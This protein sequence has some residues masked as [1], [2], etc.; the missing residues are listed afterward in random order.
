MSQECWEV[1]VNGQEGND[2]K[3]H[4]FSSIYKLSF[5][6]KLNRYQRVKHAKDARNR[7]DRFKL[8]LS[9]WYNYNNNNIDI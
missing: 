9:H 4:S 3:I 6:L 7:C 1:A 5:L 8:C 2:I